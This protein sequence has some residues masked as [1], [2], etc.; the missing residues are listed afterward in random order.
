M[1]L[2]IAWDPTNE[3]EDSGETGVAKAHARSC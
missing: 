3:W 2:F 1:Y